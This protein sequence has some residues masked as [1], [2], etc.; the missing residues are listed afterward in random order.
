MSFVLRGEHVRELHNVIH[1][2]TLESLSRGLVPHAAFSLSLP[3]NS[4]DHASGSLLK[5]TQTLFRER[6]V[7]WFHS[8]VPPPSLAQVLEEFP[9]LSLSMSPTM[10]GFSMSSTLSL[11]KCRAM[12]IR[13][14]PSHRLALAVR[15][16]EEEVFAERLEQFAEDNLAVKNEHDISIARETLRQARD[17]TSAEEDDD[18]HDPEGGEAVADN[19]RR[20]RALSRTIEQKESNSPAEVLLVSLCGVKTSNSY[21]TLLQSFPQ[22]QQGRLRETSTLHDSERPTVTNTMTLRRN[23]NGLDSNFE[24]K[25]CVVRLHDQEKEKEKESLSDEPQVSIID[26]WKHTLSVSAT[27]ENEKQKLKAPQ[28]LVTL[29]TDAAV[30]MG[31]LSTA[32]ALG[33]ESPTMLG[34]A[35]YM[36]RRKRQQA[37]D[38]DQ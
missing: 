23:C 9:S 34:L 16:R 32:A 29:P 5:D 19:H 2:L 14:P 13:A 8:L 37:V 7:D 11:H 24:Q 12:N 22:R 25:L 36:T 35:A 21:P 33:T 3:V 18:D 6:D 28:S 31:N 20:R 1:T 27:I 15:R 10:S 38:F 17:Q 30:I 4:F 26:Q